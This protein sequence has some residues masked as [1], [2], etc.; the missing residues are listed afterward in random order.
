MSTLIDIYN[1]LAE[2]G[3]D[4]FEKTAANED[5]DL[6]NFIAEAI[7]A[8][9]SQD[10][11]IE[12]LNSDD[13]DDDDDYYDDDDDDDDDDEPDE[14]MIAEAAY[15]A[16]QEQAYE[17]FIEKNASEQYG[18][19]F[20]RGYGDQM[21]ELEKQAGIAGRGLERVG[22]GL[23]WLSKKKGAVVKGVKNLG[24]VGEKTK[25]GLKTQSKAASKAHA[26]SMKRIDKL[27]A[28]LPWNSGSN[29]LRKG[30]VK[31]LRKMGLSNDQISKLQGYKDEAVSLRERFKKTKNQ[32]FLTQARD[33]E[34]KILSKAQNYISGLRTK[35]PKTGLEL[36]QDKQARRAAA[37]KAIGSAYQAAKKPVMYGAGVATLGYGAKKAIS[38]GIREAQEKKAAQEHIEL[39]L[40][41]LD[42]YGLLD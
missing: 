25:A 18:Y 20:G 26:E 22:Q 42:G 5:E 9:Y 2:D 23:E 27:K 1:E 11:I 15:E 12:A 10:D 38:G 41:I 33:L 8:G 29:L 30:N 35:A 34:T 13:D 14:E 36:I 7:E 37:I 19:I 21:R 4:M 17:D 32:A 6:D 28:S 39:A 31:T 40:E 24:K 16:G 3:E